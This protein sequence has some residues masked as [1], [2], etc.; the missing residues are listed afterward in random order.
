MGSAEIISKA[1]G[2]ML[3]RGV[4]SAEA[5]EAERR[6]RRLAAMPAP[7]EITLHDVRVR[8]PGGA[9]R[10]GRNAPKALHRPGGVV[11]VLVRRK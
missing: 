4:S 1:V 6:L 10:A 9:A 2:T 3:A 5:I 7:V 11:E 8:L